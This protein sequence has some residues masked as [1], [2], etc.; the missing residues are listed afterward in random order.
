MKKKLFF[1]LAMLTITLLLSSCTVN[2][3]RNLNTP[4]SL[5][6]A[7]QAALS[8]ANNGDVQN[9]VK[10]SEEVIATVSGTQT[11]NGNELYEALT[12][13]SIQGEKTINE[14][15]LKI[16]EVKSKLL[17]GEISPSSTTGRAVENAAIAMERS[18]LKVKKIGL[19]N[20][21][22]EIVNMLSGSAEANNY[23]TASSDASQISKILVLT[24][25]LSRD[26]PTMNL[27][28]ELCGLLSSY[29]GSSAF[30]WYTANSLYDV[31][32]NVTALF[33]SNG[34]EKLDQKDEIFKYVWDY[35][36]D[37]FKN[38]NEIDFQKV[39]AVPLAT[40]GNMSLSEKII[41]K[42]KDVS[43]ALKGMNDTL[44]TSLRN[45]SNVLTSGVKALNTLCEHINASDFAKLKDVKALIIYT[46]KS[47]NGE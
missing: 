3:F 40:Y 15:A 13:P 27:M 24:L 7:S 14:T 21:L 45:Y 16:K 18:I 42:L 29:G 44:P 31:L 30:N 11:S 9:A 37:E 22:S 36:K 25:S 28:G 6:N 23:S 47:L 38:L 39:L 12:S 10:L 8:A 32:Y 2:A 26:M 1:V 19:S 4:S 35:Q 17:N 34:N 43:C 41:E 20:T 46:E 5:V 33:D